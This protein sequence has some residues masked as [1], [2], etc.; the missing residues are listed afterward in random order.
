[1][2]TASGLAF[3]R[4]CEVHHLPRPVPEF[5]FA[6]HLGRKWR[7]DWAWPSRF[8]AL[9]IDGGLFVGGRHARGAGIRA[10]ME[11]LNE[12][13]ALGWCVLRCLP[14]ALAD[15]ATTEL[16]RRALRAAADRTRH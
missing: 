16:L 3:D 13:A 12:A 1:M 8:V 2:S 10:D 5:R 7:F 11:K 4:L 15:T 6:L 9:E 14:E